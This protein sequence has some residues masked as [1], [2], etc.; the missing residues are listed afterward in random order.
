VIIGFFGEMGSGKTLSMIRQAVEYYKNGYK[1]YANIH[2]KN[3][4]Y[5]NYTLKDLINYAIEGG[6]FSK[7]VFLLDEAHI[8]ID[9]RTSAMKKNRII[10]YFL[11]QTRKSNV[12]LLYTSQYPHQIDK[13]LRSVTSIIVECQSKIYNKRHIIL[14][15]CMKMKSNGTSIDKKIVYDAETYYKYYDTREIVLGVNDE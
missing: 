3:V 5:D 1:I 10:S 12:T 11:L 15:S 9:S 4:K 2:L 14:N 6:E 8:F 13:R 7:C